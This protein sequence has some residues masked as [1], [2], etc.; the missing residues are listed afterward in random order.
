MK[1]WWFQF[2]KDENEAFLGLTLYILSYIIIITY[3]KLNIFGFWLLA[4]QYII[5]ETNQK[6]NN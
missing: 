6:E 2:V 5:L 3:S 4:K 1:N